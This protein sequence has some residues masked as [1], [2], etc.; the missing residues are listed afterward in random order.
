MRDLD[1]APLHEVDDRCVER[2]ADGL[3]LFLSCFRAPWWLWKPP[4]GTARSR[5]TDVNG[6]SLQD[7]P[8]C[9]AHLTERNW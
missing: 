4:D 5:T 2:S 7:T 9:L 8:S 3:L 6:A 1:F